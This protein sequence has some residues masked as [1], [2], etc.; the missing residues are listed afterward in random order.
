MFT[1]SSRS[2][3]RAALPVTGAALAMASGALADLPHDIDLPALRMADTAP[4][5]A[6]GMSSM[7]AF[8]GVDGLAVFRASAGTSG[9]YQLWSSS[10]RAGGTHPIAGT[11]G[12][13]TEPVLI[14]GTHR[15]LAYTGLGSLRPLI[16]VDPRTGAVETLT[17]TAMNA[18]TT[19]LIF[20]RSNA[21]FL[22]PVAGI[23]TLW[24]TDGTAA[25]TAPVMD[26][27]AGTIG[28]ITPA[29]GF[30]YFTTRSAANVYTLW[31]TDG[32]IL[33][34]TRVAELRSPPTWL[35]NSSGMRAIG[36]RVLFAQPAAAAGMSEVWVSDGT[37][38]G[39]TVA[40]PT[41]PN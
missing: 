40:C 14:P 25:G 34:P 27:A 28:N 36:D 24:A 5:T 2:I 13:A 10:G 21:L 29:N 6:S 33:N 22:A 16:A 3:F 19:G 41:G 11:S 26:S 31:R 7:S 39:T 37:S 23:N 1:L 9:V 35:V 12:V 4:G 18:S 38:Q 17:T 30:V 20:A 32:T 15:V 8:V